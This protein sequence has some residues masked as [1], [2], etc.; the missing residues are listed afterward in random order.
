MVF[1]WKWDGIQSLAQVGQVLHQ[2]ATPLITVQ[3]YF[4]RFQMRAG[5]SRVLIAI[6]ISNQS[7]RISGLL[8]MTIDCH[9][10]PKAPHPSVLVTALVE[11]N[12]A[13][14]INVFVDCLGFDSAWASV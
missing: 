13:S 10:Y 5:A 2:W 12:L 4:S 3:E 14:H 1:W 11:K 8:R 6:D 9:I 7:K